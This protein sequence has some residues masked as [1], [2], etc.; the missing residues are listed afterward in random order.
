MLF[1]EPPV[2]FPPEVEKGVEDVPVPGDL[3]VGV[4]TSVE[5]VEEGSEMTDGVLGVASGS[6]PA[7]SAIVGSNALAYT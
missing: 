1:L 6:F 3:F 7:A 2:L 5:P 4:L